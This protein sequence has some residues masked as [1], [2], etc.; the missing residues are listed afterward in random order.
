MRIHIATKSHGTICDM[1]PIKPLEE[2]VFILPNNTFPCVKQW[3]NGKI[4][5]SP[6]RVDNV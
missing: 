1:T 4:L 5:V 6:I 3:E 2:R